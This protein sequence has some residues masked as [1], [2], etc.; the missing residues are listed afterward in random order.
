MYIIPFCMGPLN[1]KVSKYGIEITDSAYV[2]VNMKIMTRMG[3]EVLHYI[4]QNA[5]RGD[6]KPYLPCLHSVGKPLQ[7]GNLN[8]AHTSAAS[9]SVVGE[10]T[11]S[12]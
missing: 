9:P 8:P 6:A 2:V 3:I 1:S 5:Q 7:E 11:P 12:A 10:L 4:E